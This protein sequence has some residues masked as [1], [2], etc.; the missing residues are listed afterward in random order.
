M[1]CSF[2]ALLLMKE[3]QLRLEAQGH[4]VEWRR[5]LDDLEALEEFTVTS[6]GKTFVVRTATRGDAGNALQAV[7]VALGPKIRRQ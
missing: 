1:F 4:A 7:G 2:L 3:L 5:L 6:G